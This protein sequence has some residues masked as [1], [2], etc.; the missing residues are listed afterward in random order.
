MGVFGAASG[1][2]EN[3]TGFNIPAFGKVENN[4]TF[5]N[6]DQRG[7]VADVFQFVVV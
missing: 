7:S 1:G 5:K 4:I 3:M 6:T 2:R